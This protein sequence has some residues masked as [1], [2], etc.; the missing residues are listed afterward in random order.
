MKSFMPNL[1]D[2]SFRAKVHPMGA[3]PPLKG[4]PP[5]GLSRA[6]KTETNPSSFF[7][8]VGSTSQ[9]PP[10]PE[11]YSLYNGFGDSRATLAAPVRRP[12]RAQAPPEPTVSFFHQP[13]GFHDEAHGDSRPADR[14]HWK[15]S[16]ELPKWVA[17]SVLA[18]F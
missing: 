15:N 12:N 13:P 3:P 2:Y 8:G 4:S 9:V 18:H 7:L 10:P 11:R 16:S 1:F 17:G 14:H 5:P 6:E